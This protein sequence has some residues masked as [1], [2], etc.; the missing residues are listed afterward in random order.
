[1]RPPPLILGS[2]LLFWGWRTGFLWT[3][4]ILGLILESTD[5]F[6]ARWNFTD[7]EFNRLWDVCTLI[8]I[9][10]GLF[11]RYSEDVTNA[12]YKFFQWFPLI[13]FPMAFGYAFGS[14][15]AIP[16]KA[17]SWFMRRRGRAGAD[18]PMAFGWMYLATCVVTSGASNIRDVWFFF[19]ITFLIGWALF[20]IRPRRLSLVPWFAL[21]FLMATLAFLTQY[22]L[23]DVQGYFETKLS[24]LFVRFGRRGFDPRE[25]K[26][27]MGHIGSLKQSS[28]I[29]MRVKPEKGPIP[30]R[31]RESTYTSF[32]ADT[33]RGHGSF[34]NV[35]IEPD[36]TTWT[37]DTETNVTS[38]VRI[39][40]RV[41]KKFA[42]LAV[43][44]GT[45]QLRELN[46]GGIETNR[47]VAIR[48]RDNPALVN[49]SARFT[50]KS[51]DSPP[52]TEGAYAWDLRIPEPEQDTIEHIAAEI[53]AESLSH[54]RQVK[55][56][57]AFFANNFRYTTYQ[58]A[59]KLGLHAATPLSDFLLKTRAG[60][61]EYF[62]S[63]TVLLLRHFG[64]PARYVTGYAIQE[65]S[66]EDNSYVIRERHG[67]AWANAFINGRWVEV[68]STPAGWE[69]EE[70]K[71]FPFYE[72]LKDSW[73]NFTFGFLEW[74]WF[75][76][77]GFFRN[78][79]PW[80]VVPLSIFLVWRIFGRRMTHRQETFRPLEIEQGG[81]SEFYLLEKKLRRAG[82]D[83]LP[84]ETA[85][86]W[87]QRVAA[88]KPSIAMTAGELLKMHYKYR[89]DPSGLTSEERRSL[90][91]TA[92]TCL[93]KI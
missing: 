8:F 88:G 87:L 83:R 16:L 30:E 72:T 29:V 59:R 82:L 79:A 55:S 19:G 3:G 71:E 69:A 27:A 74:R 73:E 81:D 38:S 33:W 21:F 25:S 17:F 57:V 37:L 26:T 23:Q 46:V 92:R 6:R 50:D 54:E 86:Q 13:F 7:K 31:I 4:A 77:R 90:R 1:M 18:K 9:G 24:E 64:I 11:L 66:R 40:E 60:H 84:N 47:Y 75:G 67:H 76:E 15:D 41:S 36:L 2:A 43:P 20:S 45:V 39:I 65:S 93:A 85:A 32:D 91:E 10:A 61:C 58:A 53:N 78:A 80:L 48:T 56:I 68:D 5:L 12:A 62:A 89:F 70:E 14:R 49:F 35:T 63:A 51:I 34:D 28:R 52:Q 22:R 44:L 42:M